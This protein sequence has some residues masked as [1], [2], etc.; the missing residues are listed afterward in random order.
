VGRF[1]EIEQ[2]EPPLYLLV[3]DYAKYYRYARM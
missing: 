2:D 1:P 3:Q